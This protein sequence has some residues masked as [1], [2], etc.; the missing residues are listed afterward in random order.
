MSRAAACSHGRAK[1]TNSEYAVANHAEDHA[2]LH[3]EACTLRRTPFRPGLGGFFPMTCLQ[4]CLA[5][6][7][8]SFGGGSVLLPQLALDWHEVPASLGS[9]SL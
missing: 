4:T 1:Q 6:H 8:M 5:G 3:K 9:S 7:E 2:F